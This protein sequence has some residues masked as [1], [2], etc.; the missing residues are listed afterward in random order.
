[1]ILL[2]LKG[3]VFI[4]WIKKRIEKNRNAII[5]ING[6][7]GSG[8]TFAA[9]DLAFR[10]SKIFNTNFD[11]KTNM[12]F[13]F[14]NLLEKMQLPI[15]EAK[16]TVFL[17]EE[18]GAFDSG[19]SARQWQSR[20]NMFFHS[21]MQTSRHKNQILILTCPMF[22]YLE[23]GTRELVH[24]QITMKKI[25]PQN[26]TSVGKPFLLQTN[27]ISGKTYFKYMRMIHNGVKLKVREIKFRLPPEDIVSEYEALKSR[28]TINLNQK[29]ME[30]SKP[31]EKKLPHKANIDI[32]KLIDFK[33]K[34]L[35]YS[36]IAKIFNVSLMTINRYMKYIKEKAK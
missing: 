19:S 31:K 33:Q 7:T 27:P 24:L 30:D 23:K 35:S 14:S 1:M 8:K 9:I 26:K 28:Y 21:F 12:D 10:L 2:N 15:N 22:S 3:D 4:D 32:N 5:M 34:G 17:F 36:K 16:G 18:V 20:A 6:A 13:T 25:N 29:I 11:L